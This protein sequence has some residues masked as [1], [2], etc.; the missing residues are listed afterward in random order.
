MDGR[1]KEERLIT[2]RN[3]EQEHRAASGIE[4]VCNTSDFD[5][6]E[7][8]PSNGGALLD[9]LR[10]GGVNS[11][12]EPSV[13]P[14]VVLRPWGCPITS[15]I[16]FAHRGTSE[17]RRVR[18]AQSQ[19][20]RTVARLGLFGRGR[21]PSFERVG[22]SG[23]WARLGRRAE[24]T[25]I[26]RGF[27]GVAIAPLGGSFES[28][29]LLRAFE[30]GQDSFEHSR[31]PVGAENGRSVSRGTVRVSPRLASPRAACGNS[32]VLALSHVVVDDRSFERPS[33]TQMEPS[34]P[35][36]RCYPVAN[37]ARL[38][39]IVGRTAEAKQMTL[40]T[41]AALE[42]RALELG[43][44]IEGDPRTQSSSGRAPRASDYELQRRVL[45]AERGI[46]ESRFWILAV[47]SAVASVLSAAAAMIAVWK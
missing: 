13:R 45:E 42:S 29:R 18:G 15:G 5:S 3:E 43:V 12:H 26:G 20:S 39:C 34:R 37:G 40:L 17:R 7:W 35:T 41:G 11:G 10:V 16:R 25:R 1:A 27:G 4:V 9:C 19:L 31:G 47:I 8:P 14:S 21:P 24:V 22:R 32:K 38:I 28:P 2:L 30:S 23:R 33:N 6:R 46:R 44:D 36:V